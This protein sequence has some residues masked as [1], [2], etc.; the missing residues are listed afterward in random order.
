L[1]VAVCLPWEDVHEEAC[2]LEH[3]LSMRVQAALERFLDNPTSCPHGHP[4]P[5][6]DGTVAAPTGDALSL[7]VAG[8]ELEI[9]RVEEEDEGL[10]SY[11]ASLGMYPGTAVK[12]CDTAPFQGPLMIQVGDAKYAL[13][14]AVCE[15]VA[16]IPRTH[17]RRRRGQ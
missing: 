6:M 16:V 5:S 14:R 1:V 13:G 3:A 11:L 10:L 12:V 17:Q 4:I 7:H 8:D 9:V 2:V 15:K